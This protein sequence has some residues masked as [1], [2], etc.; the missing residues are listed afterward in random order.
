MSKD[1]AFKKSEYR[2]PCGGTR[3]KCDMVRVAKLEAE[4]KRLRVVVDAAQLGSCD[5]TSGCPPCETDE[6]CERCQLGPALAD[7]LSQV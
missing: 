6:F 2:C 3:H 7:Y 5:M 4:N 1:A